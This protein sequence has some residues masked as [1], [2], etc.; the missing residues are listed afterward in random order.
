MARWARH[1]VI[2]Y[3][4]LGA[5]AGALVFRMFMGFRQLFDQMM[6]NPQAPPD[7]AAMNPF[8]S[9]SPSVLAG[10]QLVNAV[11]LGLMILLLFWVY[12]AATA[13]AH[14]GIPAR[15]S[16]G[17]AVGSWFIPVINL[18]WP[19][20]ALRDML[21]V[22]HPSRRRITVLWIVWVVGGLVAAGS[23]LAWM[24]GIDA[25]L[26]TGAAGHLASASALLGGRGLIDA[27]LASHEQIAAGRSA[28]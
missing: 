6:D 21:P 1:G 5:I 7:P 20:Q 27:V 26:Y 23:L 14:L 15:R 24:F 13:A 16:P 8:L 25:A 2:A 4:F 28:L 11:Q 19:C 18:W 12:R 17:W 3:A 22:D 9:V 10:V